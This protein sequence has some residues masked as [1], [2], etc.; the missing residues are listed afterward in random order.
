MTVKLRA[1]G[2]PPCCL[3]GDPKLLESQFLNNAADSFVAV[4]VP[5]GKAFSPRRPNAYQ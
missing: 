1:L 2:A 4:E 3:M 5:D